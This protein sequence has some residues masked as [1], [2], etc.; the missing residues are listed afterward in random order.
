MVW[1]YERKTDRAKTPKEN[2]A[3]AVHAVKAGM[4]IRKDRQLNDIPYRTLA[5]Y[6]RLV[7]EKGSKAYANFGYKQSR[8]VLSDVLESELVEYDDEVETTFLQS[9]LSVNDRKLSSFLKK[10]IAAHIKLK[11][12]S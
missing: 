4:S 12:L 8:R 3:A 10:K 11:I 1:N 6:M 2:I 5:R 9:R 7:R